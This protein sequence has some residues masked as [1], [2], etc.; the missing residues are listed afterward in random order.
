MDPDPQ[1][2]G[3]DRSGIFDDQD[4]LV[5]SSKVVDPGG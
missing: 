2:E 5:V 1:P 3:I 4:P